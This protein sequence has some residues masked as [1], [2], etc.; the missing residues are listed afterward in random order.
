[1]LLCRNG[2]LNSTR[3]LLTGSLTLALAYPLITVAQD[4]HER[5]GSQTSIPGPWLL[6]STATGLDLATYADFAACRMFGPKLTFGPLKM[7]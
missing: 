2:F 1:M 5:G 3:R 6:Y 7:S 4:G